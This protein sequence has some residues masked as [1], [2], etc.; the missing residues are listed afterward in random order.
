MTFL[1][2]LISCFEKAY[3][4]ND[5]QR[6]SLENMH[7]QITETEKRYRQ[8]T[9]NSL[10]YLFV[11]P[12]LMLLSNAAPSPRETALL[13]EKI[14]NVMDIIEWESNCFFCEWFQFAGLQRL[15]LMAQSLFDDGQDIRRKMARFEQDL[16]AIGKNQK[17]LN[18]WTNCK[19]HVP[20][21]FNQI[22][23]HMSDAPTISS[24][25]PSGSLVPS[26]PQVISPAPIPAP[27]PAP[28]PTGNADNRNTDVRCTVT[29]NPYLVE[30]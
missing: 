26:V 21:A 22:F 11:I 20:E 27:N 25:V 9:A 8:D 15:K 19:R 23:K 7:G 16:Q 3:A 28:S 2:D 17:L 14:D 18:L 10:I 13:H 29:G 24:H 30:L 6:E 5:Y 12:H 4:N 1:T